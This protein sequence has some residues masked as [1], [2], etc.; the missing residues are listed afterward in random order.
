MVSFLVEEALPEVGHG[1]CIPVIA[2]KG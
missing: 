1:M 2:S